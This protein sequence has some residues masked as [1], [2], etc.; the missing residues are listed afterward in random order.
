MTYDEI[1]EQLEITPRAKSKRSPGTNM[2]ESHG[3]TTWM[4]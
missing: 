4:R 3:T 2:V 1:I